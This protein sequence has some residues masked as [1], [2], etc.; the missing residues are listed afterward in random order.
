MGRTFKDKPGKYRNNKDF[1]KK[2]QKHTKGQRPF[3]PPT[4]DMIGDTGHNPTGDMLGDNS[5]G[6]LN[7]YAYGM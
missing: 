5:I 4:D 3:T 2:Q 6:G 1:Q 7:D